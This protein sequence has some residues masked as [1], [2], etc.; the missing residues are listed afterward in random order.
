MITTTVAT[1]TTIAAE[2]AVV[3]TTGIS[4]TMS[5]I[6]SRV[7]IRIAAGIPLEMTIV[8]IAEMV[9]ITTDHL[10]TIVTGSEQY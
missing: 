5:D 9:M 2:I 1:A 10:T 7:A 8:T 3:I 6:T 4:A